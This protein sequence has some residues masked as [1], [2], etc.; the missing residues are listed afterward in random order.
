MYI[1]VILSLAI[2]ADADG[3]KATLHLAGADSRVHVH[4]RTLAPY[5]SIRTV[6]SEYQVSIATQTKLGI[7]CA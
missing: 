5:V 4:V 7:S 6:V 2:D 3:P 1:A